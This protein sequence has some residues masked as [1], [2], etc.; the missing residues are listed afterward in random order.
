MEAAAAEH[1]LSRRSRRPVSAMLGGMVTAL[2]MFAAAPAQVWSDV[3]GA[4]HARYA[5]RPGGHAWLVASGPE[6]AQ[7][8]AEAIGLWLAGRGQLLK[9]QLEL[10]V[11]D[12]LLPLEHALH[13]AAFSG[14]LVVG[15]ALAAG[16]AVLVAQR[17]VRAPGGLTYR[18]GGP[19]PAWQADF[20]MPGTASVGEQPAASLCA[21]LGVPVLVCPPQQL[22]EAL[23][24]WAATRPHGL[25]QQPES[26]PSDLSAVPAAEP[27][28]SHC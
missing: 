3:Y 20:A 9:G 6:A 23:L 14:V 25:A 4:V 18:E 1:A 26:S 13:S 11:H 2:P 15:P 10:L 17:S 22:G 21:A 27:R 16:P 5:A 8:A 24:G 28:S 19:L 12:S 7:A